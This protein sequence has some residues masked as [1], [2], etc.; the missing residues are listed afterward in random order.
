MND[1]IYLTSNS[2]AV[3]DV[4]IQTNDTSDY[5]IQCPTFTDHD[6]IVLT[7]FKYWIGGIGVCIVSMTGLLLN[8]V[9]IL[10]LLTRLSNHNNFNQ[11]M[12]ILFLVDSLYL[13]LKIIST[14]QRQF[15]WKT[16]ALVT[17][18]PHFTYPMSSISLTLSIF[19]TVGMAHERHVA[20]K[21]PIQHR[22]RM[23]SAKFRRISLLK[24]MVSIIL[25]AVSFNGPKFFEA[26]L[27]W[28]NKT[29][30]SD[31]INITDRYIEIEMKW[32]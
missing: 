5:S 21:H 27:V 16:R 7:Q 30:I 23:I 22:Q 11:L 12:V 15:G 13:I 26:E 18:Y 29:G 4:I 31:I 32:G 25:C 14:L 9:A 17:I 8:V 3:T 2:S 10:A 28:Q 1:T 24:Y 6:E 20:I 19:L